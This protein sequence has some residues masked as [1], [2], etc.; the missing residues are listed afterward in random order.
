M[1][2]PPLPFTALSLCLNRIWG[3]LFHIYLTNKH[4]IHMH[5]NISTMCNVVHSVVCV[6]CGVFAISVNSS[7][8]VY[9]AKLKLI[10]IEFVSAG[11]WVFRL[12]I[13]LTDQP[14]FRSSSLL[15][16]APLDHLLHMH[17]PTPSFAFDPSPPSSSSL[18]ACSPLTPA[19][20]K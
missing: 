9:Y 3:R 13:F 8:R 16:P 7:V 10:A 5:A 20:L 1:L 18:S 6:R 17:D 14:T 11:R 2:F 12:F 4:K 19:C 15:D